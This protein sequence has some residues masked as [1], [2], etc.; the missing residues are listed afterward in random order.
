[1]NKKN[2]IH[3]LQ[4]QYNAKIK[5]LEDIDNYIKRLQTTCNHKYI[6]IGRNGYSVYYKC[7]LCEHILET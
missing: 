3:I 4:K 2:K 5:E 7:D 6:E 1:M